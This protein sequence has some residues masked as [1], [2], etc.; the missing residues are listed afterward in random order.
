M[1]MWNGTIKMSQDII[2]GDI[3]IGD[4]GEKEL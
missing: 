2:N 3:L 4:D 1:L